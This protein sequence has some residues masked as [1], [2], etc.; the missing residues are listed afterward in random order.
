MILVRDQSDSKE[1]NIVHLDHLKNSSILHQSKRDGKP[2][3]SSS[4]I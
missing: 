2:L 3:H 4:H 1:V